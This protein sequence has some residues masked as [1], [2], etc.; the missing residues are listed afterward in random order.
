MM[1]T[2]NGVYIAQIA[3]GADRMQSLKALREA[4]SWH[5]PSLVIAYCPC[6]AHMVN[7]GLT[8]AARQQKLAVETGLWP[9][10]RY[11]PRNAPNCLTIDSKKPSKP[12]QEFTN[13]EQRFAGIA[14]KKPERYAE[15][16]GKLQKDADAEW[17]MLE[18][19]ARKAE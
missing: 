7:G 16:M 15:L 6:I 9:L 3:L 10:F 18:R 19:L 4:E 1:M 5:G 12:V 11:D 14:T 8:Y 13:L 17:L 2:Y